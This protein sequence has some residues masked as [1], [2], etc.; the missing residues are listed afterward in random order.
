MVMSPSS[1][2]DELD[3][4]E[5]IAEFLADVACSSL[6]LPHMTPGQRKQTKSVLEKYPEIVCESFGFGKERQMHLFKKHC[7][8]DSDGDSE[9]KALHGMAA[10]LSSMSGAPSKKSLQC[11]MDGPVCKLDLT[12]LNRSANWQNTLR[13]ASSLDGSTIAPSSC[14]SD[15]S[16]AST[17]REM[18]PPWL[19]PPPGL[20]ME[21]RNTFIHFGSAS[22]DTRA[23]RSMPHNMFR[24]CLLAELSSRSENANVVPVE[25]RE[26]PNP[27]N[28]KPDEPAG[29]EVLV[30]GTEVTIHGL[31]KSPAFNGLKAT[32][33][34]LDMET[35]RYN[36]LLASPVG[37]HGTAKVKP[38]NLQPTSATECL[39]LF[40]T[41]PAPE[42]QPVPAR[43]VPTRSA[44][45]HAV[46][47]LWKK[48]AT[49]STPLPLKLTALV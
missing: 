24:Q 17:F 20:E 44:R 29:E 40:S 19:G 9:N 38:E 41:A 46:R 4:G 47:A 28:G 48:A 33:Q 36:I 30:A 32:V 39:H 16:P 15:G 23:V 22:D 21:V 7:G 10:P 6:E 2:S 43:N 31:S 25:S 45:R 11:T 35:G 49:T 26:R 18:L 5:V 34:S 3:I 1:R 8:A 27:S 13:D 42:S 14:P 12:G 37:G